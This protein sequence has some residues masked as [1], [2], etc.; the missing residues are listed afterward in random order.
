M[1]L[2]KKDYEIDFKQLSEGER[3]ECPEH[4]F[5]FEKREDRVILIPLKAC[6]I[7]VRDRQP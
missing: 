6:R 4:D 7:S 3:V 2:P 5:I 1:S